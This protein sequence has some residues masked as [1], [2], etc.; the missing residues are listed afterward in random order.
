[1]IL[2]K[3]R[4][5]YAFW[6]TESLEWSSEGCVVNTFTD[7]QVRWHPDCRITGLLKTSIIII[8]STG[9]LFPINH[10]YFFFDQSTYN[11]VL[12]PQQ[13]PYGLRRFCQSDPLLSTLLWH[14]CPRLS[15]AS[16][17][18]EYKATYLSAESN[19]TL[20]QALTV[21]SACTECVFTYLDLSTNCTTCKAVGFDPSQG[22]CLNPAYSTDSDCTICVNPFKTEESNCTEC[23][24]SVWS[25]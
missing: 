9:C 12:I 19:C 22:L 2:T 4:G 6:N 14:S 24:D 1:M 3:F 8:S 15:V 11:L 17:C 16:N 5:T 13:P 21:E 23:S 7:D 20:C 10:P 25:G 18:S